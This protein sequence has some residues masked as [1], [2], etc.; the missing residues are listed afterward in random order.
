[1]LFFQQYIPTYVCVCVTCYFFKNIYL[2]M[3][4]CMC[5]CMYVCV[6]ICVYVCVYVSY[7]VDISAVTSSHDYKKASHLLFFGHSKKSAQSTL[8]FSSSFVVVCFLWS[9][10][11]LWFAGI[12][13]LCLAGNSCPLYL[14]KQLPADLKHSSRW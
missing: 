3:Y 13:N 2:C 6:C 5:V 8:V 7:S 14:G 10:S 11:L 1:M 4:V 12:S 9:S